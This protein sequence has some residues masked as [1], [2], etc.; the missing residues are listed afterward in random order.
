[1]S[2]EV[3]V[4]QDRFLKCLQDELSHPLA[5]YGT[6]TELLNRLLGFAFSVLFHDGSATRTC[7]Q[8][9]MG[10]VAGARAHAH[11]HGARGRSGRVVARAGARAGARESATEEAVFPTLRDAAQ[12]TVSA[13]AA[14]SVALSVRAVRLPSSCRFTQVRCAAATLTLT[15]SPTRGGTSQTHL[16]L[17]SHRCVAGVVCAD[18]AG[19]ARCGAGGGASQAVSL[20]RGGVLHRGAVQGQHAVCRLYNQPRSAPGPVH[21]GRPEGAAGECASKDI[22]RLAVSGGTRRCE[23]LAHTPLNRSTRGLG[24]GWDG[25]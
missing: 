8:G 25:S 7:S 5:V 17:G 23:R 1:M 15:P 24:S 20:E 11:T 2:A 3:T 16:R 9:E 10:G 18:A 14:A 12:R 19:V 22:C 6:Q 21:A 4:P 13:V